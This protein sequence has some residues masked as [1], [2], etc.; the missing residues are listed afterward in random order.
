MNK[1]EIIGLILICPCAVL[2]VMGVIYLFTESVLGG[3]I[4]ASFL[5]AMLGMGFLER[6]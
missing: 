1:N 5:L 6:G 2:I 4:V 3:F